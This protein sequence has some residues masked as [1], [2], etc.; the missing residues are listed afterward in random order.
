MVH[1]LKFGGSSISNF[2]AI[3]NVKSIINNIHATGDRTAV[4]VSAFYGVTN[5]L[6]DAMEC[7]KKGDITSMKNNLSTLQTSHKIISSELNVEREAIDYIFDSTNRSFQEILDTKKIKANNYDN[8][9]SIGEKLSASI[10]S[11]SEDKY[12][13]T[14]DVIITNNNYGNSYPIMN[15]TKEKC[16]SIT[17]SF[18]Q[19]KIPVVP[20]FFGHT[21]NGRITTMG[22]GGSDLTSTVIANCIGA[23]DISFYKVECNSKGDWEKGLVGIIHP[24]KETI[25]HLSFSEMHEMGNLGRTVLHGSTMKPIKFN[26]DLTIHI[27][28]TLE[29][30]KAG[31]KI[32]LD[33]PKRSRA[34]PF[35]TMMNDPGSN[36]V[37]LIGQHHNFY[38]GKKYTDQITYKSEHSI[39]LRVSSRDEINEIFNL[40]LS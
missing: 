18:S 14:G 26:R 3:K 6:I 19:G 11:S 37:H 2:K 32:T 10:I 1:V 33:G 8:I 17:E 9:V 21:M 16:I 22:R 5:K 30:A 25:S 40:Y 4:V 35:A 24:N 34:A 28:N 23:K 20:G 15:S 7:A 27:K 29:P 13:Y 31:T 36:L 38:L 39:T 12:K